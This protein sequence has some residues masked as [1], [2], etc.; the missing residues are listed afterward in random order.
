MGSVWTH[1]HWLFWGTGYA[2]LLL[3]SPMALMLWHE[4]AQG[5]SAAHV[6]L[7]GPGLACLSMAAGM[8]R[9]LGRPSCTDCC[10]R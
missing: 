10:R 8:L 3:I 5:V 2:G 7:A 4:G 9:G 1:A 6:L